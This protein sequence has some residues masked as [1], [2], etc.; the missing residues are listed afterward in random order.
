MGKKKKWGEYSEG[1]ISHEKDIKERERYIT[2]AILKKGAQKNYPEF[3]IMYLIKFVDRI[4]QEFNIWDKK[5]I[6]DIIKTTIDNLDLMEIKEMMHPIAQGSYK[7]KKITLYKK[8]QSLAS[9]FLYS[10]KKVIGIQNEDRL[11]EWKKR[12]KTISVAIHELYHAYNNI[13][14][15]R[16]FK[17]GEA[18]YA[19][20]SYYAREGMLDMVNL[21]PRYK[22]WFNMVRQFVE[23]IGKEE[24]FELVN[25]DDVEA[26]IDGI[27]RNTNFRF[28]IN[29]FRALISQMNEINVGADIGAIE[30]EYDMF[31]AK[32][33]Y[34]KSLQ[35]RIE[36]QNMLTRIFIGKRCK[37]LGIKYDEAYYERLSDE[38]LRQ[39]LRIW[40]EYSELYV[41]RNDE[42]TYS[43]CCTWQSCKKFC[44]ESI[45][46]D[47]RI[48]RFIQSKNIPLAHV[49]EAQ[50][51]ILLP[52]LPT[53]VDIDSV[54]HSSKR[55]LGQL[56]I[57]ERLGKSLE[58]GEK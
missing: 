17:E 1:T 16:A 37:Q 2:V 54:L 29:R 57:S 40:Q 9:K 13:D 3:L 4:V 35:I 55:Y 15:M 46:I 6:I 21:N 12:K 26:R 14:G 53:G 18:T 50:Q 38:Q 52:E 58:Q 27:R 20:Y 39:E 48:S 32:D 49:P 51:S 34:I 44:D 5:K 31:E 41:D 25:K 19:E 8:P 24:Y 42:E 45:R 23:F 30:D 7:D 56:A 10:L 33:Q 43:R 28:N 22:I 36:L 47:Q 11:D